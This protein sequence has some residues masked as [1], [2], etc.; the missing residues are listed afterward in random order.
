M[1]RDGNR[2]DILG[3]KSL[4]WESKA[5]YFTRDADKGGLAKI[6]PLKRQNWQNTPSGIE[7]W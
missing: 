6:L 7:N 5:R 4:F 2:I 1:I 3:Y